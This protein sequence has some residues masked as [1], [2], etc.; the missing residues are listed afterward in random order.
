MVKPLLMPSLENQS[1]NGTEE[2]LE[3]ITVI[4]QQKNTKQPG[5]GGKQATME[6]WNTTVTFAQKT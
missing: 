1:L 3:N 4:T 2:A 6:L 5:Q